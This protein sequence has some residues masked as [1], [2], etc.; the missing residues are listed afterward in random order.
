ML[1][2][3]IIRNRSYDFG[4][5]PETFVSSNRLNVGSESNELIHIVDSKIE[6]SSQMAVYK[7][8]KN[9]CLYLFVLISL[10]GLCQLAVLP[11]IHRIF[12]LID[13]PTIPPIPPA[14]SMPKIPK[15]P[16]I[17][18]IP[19]IPNMPSLLDIIEPTSVIVL[20]I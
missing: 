11:N 3:N 16:E 19:Q 18:S 2:P 10:L 15:I 4:R 12:D 1:P 20:S 7:Y 6:L 13:I 5:L 8:V 9:K 17:P 14:P